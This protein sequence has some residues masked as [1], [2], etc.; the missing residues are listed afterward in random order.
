MDIKLDNISLKNGGLHVI[1]PYCM[2][3]NRVLEQC[4]G[5]CG[6]Q[7]QPGSS[8][9][10]VSDDD[11]YYE[12]KDFDEKFENLLKLQNKF[13]NY[14]KNNWKWLYDYNNYN[15]ADVEYPFNISIENM[16]ELTLNRIHKKK[17]DFC[18]SYYDMIL[19]AWGIFYSRVEQNLDKYKT[20]A[21]MEKEF[22]KKF[23]K[24]LNFWIPEKCNSLNEAIS[25][26]TKEL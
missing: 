3:N 5:R 22:D 2:E 15:S 1:I 25:H 7:G 26:I 17:I 21:I 8:T 18:S 24:K 6:R 14:I 16:I 13:A 23:M 19:K 10:Y 20:Y 9:L 4:I 11:F 12:T